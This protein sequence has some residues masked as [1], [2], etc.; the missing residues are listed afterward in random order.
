MFC[1][2]DKYFRIK[3]TLP[4][5]FDTKNLSTLYRVKKPQKK[6]QIYTAHKA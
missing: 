2:K 6:N 4:R 1:I 5:Q 3:Y